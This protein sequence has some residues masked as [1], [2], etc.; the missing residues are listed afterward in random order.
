QVGLPADWSHR[1][2]IF[3]NPGSE[4]LARQ[5][6]THERWKKIVS[7]PRYDIE[8][9]TLQA[10]AQSRR[11]RS[12]ATTLFSFPTLEAQGNGNAFGNGNNDPL[13][14]DWSITTNRDNAGGA[15]S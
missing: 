9:R 3:S 4:D 1:H 2:L 8:Y 15:F 13:G 12:V 14:R 10:I 7:D 11:P 6:G 5:N